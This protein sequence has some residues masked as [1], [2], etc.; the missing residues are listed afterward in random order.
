MSPG[1]YATKLR[2][3]SQPHRIMCVTSTGTHHVVNFPS[4]DLASSM[5]LLCHDCVQACVAGWLGGCC[6]PHHDKAAPAAPGRGPRD[7]Q[8][9]ITVSD[10]VVI[11]CQSNSVQWSKLQLISTSQL[12]LN[13]MNRRRTSGY[14]EKD[15]NETPMQ[16]SLPRNAKQTSSTYRACKFLP[17]CERVARNVTEGV[18]GVFQPPAPTGSQS[19]IRGDCQTSAQ[20]SDS[21]CS[22][23][24]SSSDRT[25]LVRPS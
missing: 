19:N 16:S 3:R 2:G 20:L 4:L 8:H 6:C 22:T 18:H 7:A 15:A 10:N 12:S 9:R 25:F 21:G 23:C 14:I 11:M 24:S 17:V 1:G 13:L 5:S